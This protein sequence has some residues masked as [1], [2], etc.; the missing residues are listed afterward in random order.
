MKNSRLLLTWTALAVTAALAMGII[1]IAG[2]DPAAVPSADTE[3]EPASEPFPASPPDSTLAEV[4][5]PDDEPAPV[6]P[7]VSTTDEPPPPDQ[8]DVIVELSVQP[9]RPV[10]E[11]LAEGGASREVGAYESAEGV[12]SEVLLDELIVTTDDPAALDGLLERRNGEILESGEPDEF[13]DGYTDHLVRIDPTTA[14]PSSLGA[15]LLA[16]EP[17][18]VGTLSA[19]SGDVVALLAIAADETA[20]HGLFVTPNFLEHSDDVRVDGVDEWDPTGTALGANAF[21]W[22]WL[23]VGGEQDGGVSAAWQMLHGWG[24]LGN[25]VDLLVVDEGFWGNGDM[26]FG[27]ETRKA[28]WKKYGWG[29]SSGTVSA[30]HGT[31]V[32][33]AAAGRFDNDYGMAGPGSPVV[34]L[35][36]MSG[37]SGTW[38]RM[39]DVLRVVKDVRPDIVTMSLSSDINSFIGI[40]Q[41]RIDRIFRKVRDQYG[42]LPFASA[43]NDSRNIDSGNDLVLPCE[44]RFVV[45]VGGVQGGTIL[46]WDDGSLVENWYPLAR[47]PISNWGTAKNTGS[48]EIWGPHC[49]LGI[50]DPEEP[51]TEGLL[52]VCG[53][54]FATPHVAGVAAL[55]KAANPGLDANELRS[56]LLATAHQDALGSEVTG[57]VA[58]ID[59]YRAVATAMNRPYSAPVFTQVAPAAGTVFL[60]EDFVDLEGRF[61]SYAGLDLPIQWHRPDG[62]PIGDPTLE[63]VVVSDLAPGTQVFTASATDIF[64]GT[65]HAQVVIEVANREPDVSITS[66]SSNAYRYE[67]EEI[68]LAGSTSDPDLLHQELPDDAVIWSIRR[69]GQAGPV[70]SAVGHQGSIP[71]GVLSAGDYEVEMRGTDLGN[72]SISDTT[73]LTILPIPPG[74]SL[75]TVTIISPELGS[76]FGAGGTADSIRVAAFASDEQDGVIPGTRMR[77]TASHGDTVIVLC[78]GGEIGGSAGT[79]CSDAI[80]SIPLSPGAPTN[81]DWELNVQAVDS[82]NLPGT[83]T[84]IITVDTGVG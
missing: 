1:T 5:E 51:N 15:N 55:V 67:G 73:L 56:V 4:P 42:A 19:S 10:I 75:P 28:S 65:S 63:P 54:S 39:R 77:W 84:A 11:P 59:A 41:W 37:G 71:G 50:W 40:N 16:I 18:H 17:F 24:G 35:T 64:G 29:E 22:P 7:V 38:S 26:P 46:E 12:V 43:S 34:D 25:R 6:P 58:R 70:F 78:E 36:V 83:A 44:S 76:V 80:V 2:D 66:P 74:E 8:L 21:E 31:H 81:F 69:I 27:V 53:T 32:F 45:C 79:D 72:A 33:N 57:N 52:P 3:S 68:V 47:H 14:D 62:S 49:V 61:T 48:V 60:Q 30:F 82:A 23:Q 13:G 20:N 9:I